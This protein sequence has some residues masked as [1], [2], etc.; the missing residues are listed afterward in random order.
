MHLRRWQTPSSA[1]GE[2]ARSA[3]IAAFTVV[4]SEVWWV[5]ALE[6]VL[7]IRLVEV[8]GSRCA[9]RRGAAVGLPMHAVS[10]SEQLCLTGWQD[11]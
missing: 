4:L 1:A 9:G 6:A 2:Q 5:D 8:V 3:C 10:C 7:H 11:A